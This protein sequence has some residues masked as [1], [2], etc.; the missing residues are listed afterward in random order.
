VRESDDRR[1]ED[2]KGEG[3]AEERQQDQLEDAG[4]VGARE[5]KAGD[6]AGPAIS[7]PE[8]SKKPLPGCSVAGRLFFA[9]TSLKR[10]D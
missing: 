8:R 9:R 2:L 4:G 3:R 6:D 5:A 10:V 1:N 7:A